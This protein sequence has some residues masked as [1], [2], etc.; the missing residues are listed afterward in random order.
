MNPIRLLPTFT[1]ATAL[2][3]GVAL[4]ARATDGPIAYRYTQSGFADGASV[5]GWFVGHDNDIDGMLY[6]SELSDFGF[7]FSGNRAV[8]AFTMGMDNRAG[9]VFDI[10]A[11]NL[12]HLAVVGPGDSRE[13]EYDAYGWPG[14]HIP[15]RVTS[16]LDGLISISWERLEV[17]PMAPVPEPG[18]AALWLCGLLAV[19]AFTG[20]A[21][22]SHRRAPPSRG[23]G[24]T[25]G[26]ALPA[27]PMLPPTLPTTTRLET[28]RCA[29][30]VAPLA[31]TSSPD[32]PALQLP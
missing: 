3:L 23:P 9:L 20:R 18:M 22:G 4:P 14:F 19:A 5:S 26:K 29:T 16:N 10:A 24:S 7:S 15:G 31:A 30:P 17:A 28:Q 12:M 11:A 27:G 21:A 8:P 13:L 1:V 6:A 32:R 25:V 2:A